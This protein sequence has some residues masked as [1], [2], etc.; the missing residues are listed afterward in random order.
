MKEITG[1]VCAAKGFMAGAIRCGIKASSVKDDTAIIYS[2]APC[3]TAAVYTTNVVKADCLKVTKEHLSNGIS[4]AVIVNSGNANACAPNGRIN[5][6]KEAKACA[7]LVGVDVSDVIVASTG[8]IGQELPVHVIVDNVPKLE[9]KENNSDAAANAIMTTDTVMKTTAVE[10]DVNGT[11]VHMG[12]I[13]KGSGMIHPNMGTMLCFITTDAKISQSLLQKALS[14]IVK[15]T[16]NRVSVDGDTSTNDMCVVM[17]NGLAENVE[18]NSEDATYEAFYEALHQ[19]MKT[20]A[21]KIASDGEGASRLITVTVKNA[22]TEDKAETLAKSVASSSLFKAAMFGSDANW[23]RVLCAMGYS[24]AKFD[25]EKVDVDF[26]SN[27]GKVS[28]CASGK[29]LD[30]D[31]DLAKKVLSEDSVVVDIDVHEGNETVTAWGCDLTY[32]YV[33]INGDYRT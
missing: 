10:F 31:E 12:G 29:A 21:I 24:G 17:A 2:K 7:D 13:C 1:G 15:V 22:E 23:G 19:V 9:V 27:A 14:S 3:N 25:P 26:L 33:K 6:E 18:I 28:V 32:D 30:F 11:T 8:V 5:A 4:Q 16:F 20:L